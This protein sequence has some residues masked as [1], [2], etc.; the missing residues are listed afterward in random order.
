ME[1]KTSSAYSATLSVSAKTKE[2][3]ESNEDRRSRKRDA[4]KGVDRN[5]I[6]EKQESIAQL[7][8]PES[9]RSVSEADS[10]MSD[11]TGMV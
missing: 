3:G 6:L 8:S 7:R 11:P 2:G 5:A 1:F 10:S 9:N 4:P